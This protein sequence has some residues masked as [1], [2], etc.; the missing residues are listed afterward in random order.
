MLKSLFRPIVVLVFLILS[1]SY[2]YSTEQEVGVIDGDTEVHRRRRDKT[3]GLPDG[4]KC[5]LQCHDS[6]LRR[7]TYVHDNPSQC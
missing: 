1:L 6:S 2:V 3:V 5:T 4:G 7:C